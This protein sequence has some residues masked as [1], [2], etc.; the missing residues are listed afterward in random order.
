MI[1]IE[2]L[3]LYPILDISKL[4]I[5][6]LTTLLKL[7]WSLVQSKVDNGSII[8]GTA[9]KSYVQMLDPIHNQGLRLAL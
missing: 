8:Y 6:D 2:N 9:G 3:V 4:N 1:L 5:S 7:Y